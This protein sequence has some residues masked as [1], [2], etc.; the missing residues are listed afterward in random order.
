ML[1]LPPTPSNIAKCDVTIIKG[2]AIE[3]LRNH[4]YHGVDEGLLYKYFYDPVCNKIVS[5]FPVTLAPNTLTLLGF[6][7]VITPFIV[8]LSVSGF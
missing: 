4:K 5:H 7:C 1:A 6:I 2:V 8:L 3:N